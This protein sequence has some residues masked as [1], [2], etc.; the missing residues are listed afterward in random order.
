MYNVVGVSIGIESGTGTVAVAEAVSVSVSVG[1]GIGI[2][3][4]VAAVRETGDV[5]ILTAVVW[6]DAGTAEGGFAFQ[7][8]EGVGDGR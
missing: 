8:A 6:S 7:I 3:T 5:G 2:G 4:V 1:V